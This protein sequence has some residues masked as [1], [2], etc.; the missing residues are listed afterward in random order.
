MLESVFDHKLPP[1][2]HE[3]IRHII[4]GANRMETLLGDLRIY[5]QVSTTESEAICDIEATEVLNRVLTNLEAAINDSR[6]SIVTS[7]L[8]RIR[9]HEF[10][11]E[12]ILQNLIGNAIRYRRDVRLDIS[13]GAERHEDDWLFSVEDN[14]IGIESEYREQIFG[15]FKRLH[16]FAKYPGTGMGL[17]ICQR[18]IER[19]GGRIWVESEVGKGS[20]FFFTIPCGE[21]ART[22]ARTE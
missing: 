22:I 13:V 17:A 7:D 19:A 21:S 5:T 18:I 11:L 20:K 16:S 9:M 1:K 2:G 3:F 12:Q 15:V 10:E 14:G 6:A 8:P 4:E